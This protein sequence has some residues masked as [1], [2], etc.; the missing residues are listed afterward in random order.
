MNDYL[1]MNKLDTL[2]KITLI[3]GLLIAG[4]GNHVVAQEIKTTLTQVHF[5]QQ[6]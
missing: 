3:A 5:D 4:F 6:G 1:Y 2:K